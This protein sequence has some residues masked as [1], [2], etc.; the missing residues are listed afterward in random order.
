MF[1]EGGQLIIGQKKT[2][3]G[4]GFDGLSSFEGLQFN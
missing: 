2:P 1:L 4:L 3:S